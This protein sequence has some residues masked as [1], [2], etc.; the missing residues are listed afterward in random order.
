MIT[1]IKDIKEKAVPILKKAG[2]KYS[3]IFGSYV[4]GE[5]KTNSDID[6]L[7]DFPSGLS[8]FDVAEIKYTLED[9]L[10][11]KIDLVDYKKIKPRLK[12]KILSEQIQIL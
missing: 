3:A 8:L 4:R 7:V 5:Q 12:P 10:G 1:A 6:I 2:I 9:T 11:K